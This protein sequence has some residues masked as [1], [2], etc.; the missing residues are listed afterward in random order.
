MVKFIN[1]LTVF[2]LLNCITYIICENKY[3]MD[4][5]KQMM[6]ANLMTSQTPDG[7]NYTNL[8]D[9]SPSDSEVDYSDKP[10]WETEAANISQNYNHLYYVM[11]F[12]N[13]HHTGNGYFS[14]SPS[15]YC[16]SCLDTPVGQ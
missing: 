6:E 9:V 12:I 16:K 14:S 8:F 7:F 4:C 2:C 5:V 3:N 13:N 11:Q 10:G 15:Q 1:L